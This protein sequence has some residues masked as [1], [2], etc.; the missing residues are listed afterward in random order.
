MDIGVGDAGAVCECMCLAC[1]L[2]WL[3][4]GEEVIRGLAQVC[5]VRDL[6]KG[7][8]FGKPVEGEGVADGVGFGQEGLVTSVMFKR[9]AD[10]VAFAAVGGECPALVGCFEC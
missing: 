4:Q 10:V 2:C 7:D 9:G 3:E 5:V 8:C 6:W 1:R